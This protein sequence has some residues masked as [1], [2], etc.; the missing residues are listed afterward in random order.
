MEERIPTVT[1]KEARILL[2]QL[3]IIP[4]ERDSK[5]LKKIKECLDNV[6]FFK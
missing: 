4:S 5:C 6:K 1:D 3:S 2:D